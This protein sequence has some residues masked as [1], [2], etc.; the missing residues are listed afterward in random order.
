MSPSLTLR[1][2]VLTHADLE[3]ICDGVTLSTALT[4][5]WGLVINGC[6]GKSPFEEK[7]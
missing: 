4:P 5:G 6:H 2:S 3:D 1:V 7:N